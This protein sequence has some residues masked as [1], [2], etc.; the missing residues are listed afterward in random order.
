MSVATEYVLH[1]LHLP[2]GEDITQ[3]EEHQNNPNVEELTAASAGNPHDHFAATTAVKPDFTCSTSQ[4]KTLLDKFGATSG[5]ATAALTGGNIDLYYK[6]VDNLGLRVAAATAQHRR[7]RGTAAMLVLNTLSTDHRGIASIDFRVVFQF[8]GVNPPLVP[9]GNLALVGTPQAAQ[10]YTLGPL[11]VN[12][13][14]VPAIVSGRWN[15]AVNL[16]ADGSE[17][18]VYDSYLAAQTV[19]SLFSFGT[20]EVGVWDTLGLSGAKVLS[21]SGGAV[22][23]L[24][25]RDA[26]GMY[27]ANATPEHI[28]ISI[29]HGKAVVLN[30]SGGGANRLAHQLQ[31]RAVQPSDN[32]SPVLINTAVAIPGTL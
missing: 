19:N 26:N 16:F 31:I 4:V 5:A 10:Q 15:A 7:F 21:G 11:L 17:S 12:G 24:R 9:A 8:D 22:W 2:T 29:P 20:L 25:K 18:E 14:Q 6:K 27:V 32:S 13:V 3:L 30:S 1:N 23:Y 28:S